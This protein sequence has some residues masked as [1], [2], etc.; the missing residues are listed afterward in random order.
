M[1]KLLRPPPTRRNV[2][3]SKKQPWPGTIGQALRYNHLRRPGGATIVWTYPRGRFK[4]A[5]GEVDESL[6]PVGP[7]SSLCAPLCARPDRRP[8][9]RRR[10]CAGGA[11][12]SGGG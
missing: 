11:G 9:G 10:L 3:G 2:L 7:A 12:S 8:T 6:S 4:A 5:K 1:T